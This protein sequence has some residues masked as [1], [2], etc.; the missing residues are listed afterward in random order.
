MEK[1]LQMTERKRIFGLNPN[2]FFLGMVSLLTDVSSEMIFTLLSLFLSNV[3]GASTTIIGLIGGLS[4]GADATFR[5]F[6]G[7]FSDK[8]GKRKSLTVIGYVVSTIARPFMYLA[9]SWGIVLGVRFGDRV[10]K[11]IRTSS[12]DALIAD[13]ISVGERGKGFGL[14]RAS[15]I[16]S[17]CRIGVSWPDPQAPR[18]PC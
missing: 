13:S 11:G 7:W 17:R 2:V 8:I 5:I 10:G 14:H 4:E 15:G 12:R 1:Q 9:S 18:T 16:R 6:S 3:L